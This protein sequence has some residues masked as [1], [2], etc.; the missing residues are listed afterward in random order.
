MKSAEREHAGVSCGA[1]CA[2]RFV[3]LGPA[4]FL[5]L[6]TRSECSTEI[7]QRLTTPAEC[8]LGLSAFCQRNPANG[9][10]TK[11]SFDRAD[12]CSQCASRRE[13]YI[14]RLSRRRIEM[15]M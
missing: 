7:V 9:D 12:G 10:A 5:K 1:S 4:R 8:L 13:N 11:P 14:A 3:P 2:N 15:D 6:G